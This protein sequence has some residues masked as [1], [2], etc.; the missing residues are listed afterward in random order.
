[1]FESQ[2][3]PVAVVLGAFRTI[4]VVE[5][6]EASITVALDRGIISLVAEKDGAPALHYIWRPGLSVPDRP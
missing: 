1:M 2:Q 3:P 4:M 6:A 5:S